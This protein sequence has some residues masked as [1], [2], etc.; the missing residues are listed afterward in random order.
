MAPSSPLC[1]LSV[2]ISAVAA[3]SS[4][5]L[6]GRPLFL[7]ASVSVIGEH[8]LLAATLASASRHLR[9][10][11]SARSL[12][13]PSIVLRSSSIYLSRSSAANRASCS[14]AA[15]NAARSASSR[16]MCLILLVNVACHRLPFFLVSFACPSYSASLRHLTL[17]RSRLYSVSCLRDSSAVF[18]FS[19]A[20]LH[21]VCF[22][23]SVV[24]HIVRSS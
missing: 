3:F 1:F 7:G 10:A 4:S 20:C 5:L 9:S 22:S 6:R 24:V 12:A 18:L 8:C 14:A 17:P 23:P 2:L 11:T 13:S 21:Y 19:L 16:L 15:C